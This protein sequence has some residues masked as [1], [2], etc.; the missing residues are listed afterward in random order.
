MPAWDKEYLCMENKNPY[1]K[2]TLEVLRSM[3]AF[4]TGEALKL[5]KVFTF[6]NSREGFEY[7]ISW[8]QHIQDKYK[9]SITIIVIEPTGITCCTLVLILRR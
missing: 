8:I 5:G 2:L 3:P 4:L 6:S 1:Q 9:K 7:F